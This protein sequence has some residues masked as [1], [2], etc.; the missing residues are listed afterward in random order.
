M[1]L[2]FVVLGRSI[3][4]VVDSL[5]IDIDEL[6]VQIALGTITEE[7]REHIWKIEDPEVLSV[8]AGTTDVRI[9][10]AVAINPHVS[11]E[12]LETMYKSDTVFIVKDVAWEMIDRRCLISG[13]VSPP[14]PVK[15]DED[16]FNDLPPGTQIYRS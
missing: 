13:Q 8:L 16:K 3:K 4:S 11:D 12:I 15:D 6:R 9:R 2:V 5:N 14:R 10:T 1:P 7:I